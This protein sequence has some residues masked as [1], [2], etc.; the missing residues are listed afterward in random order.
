M[1]CVRCA[2]A[3]IVLAFFVACGGSDSLGHERPVSSVSFEAQVKPVS[4]KNVDLLF[5]IDD[6]PSMAD[7][8]ATLA[9]QLQT[10]VTRLL[11]PRCVTNDLY[12]CKADSDCSALGANATCALEGFTRVCYVPSVLGVC[13]GS[14][15]PEFAPVHDLHVA[16]VRSS[17]GCAPDDGSHLFGGALPRAQPL[18]GEGGGFL[19]WLPR[20]LAANAQKPAPNVSAYDDGEDGPFVADFGSLVSQV[21]TSG[22]GFESQLESWYRFLVQPDPWVSVA[23]TNGAATLVGVDT[24]LLAMRHDFLRPDSLVAIVQITDEDDASIDPLA[25][26]GSAAFMRQVPLGPRG[27]SACDIDPTSP[28]CSS[29]AFPEN[30][31]DPNCTSCA[32]GLASCPKKGWYAPGQDSLDARFTD[33]MSRRYGLDPQWS[34]QRYVD[35]LRLW[36]APDRDHEVHDASRWADTKRNCTN[37]LFAAELP[38]GSD[39]SPGAL[40]NLRGG[41]RTPDLVFYALIGG[42]APSLLVDS[43]GDFKPDLASDDWTKLVG[44]PRD[45][46]MIESIAPRPGLPP[47]SSTSVERE[48]NTSNA[49]GVG[50]ASSSVDLQF[51]CTFDLPTPRD[52]TI[53]S[54]CDCAPGS[55]GATASDGP[56]LCDPNARTRQVRGKAYPSTRE[57]RVAK[58]LGAQSVVRS[59]CTPFLPAL[60]AL[61]D[62]LVTDV[63]GQCFPETLHHLANCSVSCQL[64]IEYPSQ[65]DQSAGC[66]DPGTSQPDPATLDWFRTRYLASFGDAGW[67]PVPVACVYRQLSG[68]FPG[69][70]N[71]SPDFTGAT[72][73]GS[74]NEGWCYVEGAANTGGCPQGIVFGGAGPPP[75]T[76]LSL[77]CLQ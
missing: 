35:G 77:T 68:Q 9:P 12:E 67:E 65:T 49:Q 28:A 1:R 3:V 74:P 56:P 76:T 58:G 23:T 36:T 66:T 60:T 71:P 5:A 64:L 69:C 46:R 11:S 59:I 52:C 21:G 7:K 25:L 13:P 30:A 63:D 75:G 48:W 51:A 37:P 15:R 29:C 73:A 18:N 32:G 34:V 45:P 14:T 54:P 10:I 41:A 42:V 20:S 22:C 39:S 57:L 38:D 33:D 55:P 70:S 47:P 8:Q 43:N 24:T 61:F 6:S 17:L 53:E 26:G 62:R 27:T 19:A 16:V 31:S 40:C 4:L 44:A 72:C 2:F 50:D